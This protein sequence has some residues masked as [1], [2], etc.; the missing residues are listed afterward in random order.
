MAQLIDI[1]KDFDL[2]NS[3]LLETAT[4]LAGLLSD[5]YRI[6]VK[7]DSQ[8]YNFSNDNKK[9]ILFAT[10]RETHQTPR[11]CDNEKVFMIFHNYAELD[12]WGYPCYGPKVF[13]LPLGPFINN[14]QDKVENIKP[15]K[16][17]E[18]DFCF[19][20]QIPHTG[21]RDKFQRCLDKM[22]AEAGDKF[23]YYVKYTKNFGNGLDHDEY[24]E[25][26]NN[27]KVCLC[28]QG[29]FS[30][31]SFRFFEALSLGCVPML[32]RV[33]KFWYYE[34]APISFAR[35]EFLDKFMSKTL[36]FLNSEQSVAILH[37][38]ALYNTTILNPDWLANFFK[39]QIERK[40]EVH[41]V[42]TNKL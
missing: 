17:R 37:G 14:L 25:L 40:I 23:K 30:E 21:T 27:S 18:Y 16:E 20:G 8:D 29:A 33:P 26:L 35:W 2:G 11:Y 28:P 5:E 34:K 22:I 31:E 41:N 6:I 24:I 7:Y 3:F 4:K 13:P 10:S 39:Y 15:I 12:N 9:N 32:E 42:P 38:I 1:K 36:N 19:V